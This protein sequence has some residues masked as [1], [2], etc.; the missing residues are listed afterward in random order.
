MKDRKGK[1]REKGVLRGLGQA[2]FVS[3]KKE[4]KPHVMP[5]KP[6]AQSQVNGTQPVGE[7]ASV[8]TPPFRHGFGEHGV[9]CPCARTKHSANAKAR[10]ITQAPSSFFFFFLRDFAKQPRFFCSAGAPPSCH[11]LVGNAQLGSLS[12]HPPAAAMGKSRGR[13]AREQAQKQAEDHDGAD[14]AT[15]IRVVIAR[16]K[17]GAA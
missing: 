15:A 14:T 1:E 5:S 2:L 11:F 7:R 9:A 17:A 6:M 4:R 16:C 8:Q 10:A 13:R 3:V 12:Y